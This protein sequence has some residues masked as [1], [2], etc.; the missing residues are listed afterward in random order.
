MATL[1]KLIPD[2]IDAIDVGAIHTCTGCD[3]NNNRCILLDNLEDKFGMLFD[4]NIIGCGTKLL[5]IKS[6]HTIDNIISASIPAI[7][8]ILGHI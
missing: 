8:V 5:H 1:L 2:M 4:T 6:G 3:F 7:N